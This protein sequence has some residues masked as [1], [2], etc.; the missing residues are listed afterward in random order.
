VNGIVT[1][2]SLVQ[3]RGLE[4][5]GTPGFSAVKPGPQHCVWYHERGVRA[6]GGGRGPHPLPPLLRRGEGPLRGAV[7]LLGSRWPSV[8]VAHWPDPRGAD[9]GAR[10]RRRCDLRRASSGSAGGDGMTADF[11]AGQGV[12]L[13]R[14]APLPGVPLDI[15]IEHLFYL[16]KDLVPWLC[17]VRVPAIS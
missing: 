5:A 14:P 15:M 8:R 10:G 11:R 9:P 6:G 13:P 17:S 16:L 4:G 12:A 2:H 3:E 7:S 1:P